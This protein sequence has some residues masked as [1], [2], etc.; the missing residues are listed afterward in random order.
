MPAPIKISTSSN[1]TPGRAL[2]HRAEREDNTC[3]RFRLS[4]H[5]AALL[6]LPVH[7]RDRSQSYCGEQHDRIRLHGATLLH[8]EVSTETQ[9]PESPGIATN[10]PGIGVAVEG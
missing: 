8:I 9:S 1:A 3:G 4:M 5:T 2:T 10:G 7:H 6:R